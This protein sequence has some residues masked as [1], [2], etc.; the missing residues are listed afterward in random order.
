[1]HGCAH[2]WL[3]LIQLVGVGAAF[4]PTFTTYSSLGEVNET[5]I[6]EQSVHVAAA[7]ELQAQ[8]IREVTHA[9]NQSQRSASQLMR[10]INRNGHT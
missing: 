4:V 7:S 10:T 8:S 1:M 9:H 2:A 3:A 6:P 5:R